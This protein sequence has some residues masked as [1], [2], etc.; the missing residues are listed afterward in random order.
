MIV[1]SKVQRVPCLS[2]ILF[3]TLPTGYKVYDI[4]GLAREGTNNHIF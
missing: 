4:S 3:A 1:Y 2:H